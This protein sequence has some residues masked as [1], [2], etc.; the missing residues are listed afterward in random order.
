MS[1]R[2]SSP[3]KIFACLQQIMKSNVPRMHYTV[4]IF[5]RDTPDCQSQHKGVAVVLEFLDACDDPLRINV[6]LRVTRA[7]RGWCGFVPV[8]IVW[9]VKE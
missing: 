4:P 2:E 8:L 9:D 7:V 5:L 1:N 3:I 6:I